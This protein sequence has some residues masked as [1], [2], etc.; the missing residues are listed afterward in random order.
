MGN[1][2]QGKRGTKE[3]GS[4]IREPM[5]DNWGQRKRSKT[6][7]YLTGNL[8]VGKKYTPGQKMGLEAN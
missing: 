8:E 2:K 7:T 3:K 1:E 6:E 5:K 4:P